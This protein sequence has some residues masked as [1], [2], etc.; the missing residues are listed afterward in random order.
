VKNKSTETLVADFRTAAAIHGRALVEGAPRECNRAYDKL[1]RIRREL[2]AR[3]IEHRRQL[4]AL[5]DDPDPGVRNCAAVDALALE[6]EEGLRVLRDVA[7]GPPSMLEL[8][9]KMILER[10]D[11][12]EWDTSIP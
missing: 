2:Q 7:A 11:A 9:A 12:G 4:L 10:W 6:P 8:D 1:T 5:L 3:G